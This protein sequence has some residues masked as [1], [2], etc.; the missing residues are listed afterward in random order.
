MLVRVPLSTYFYVAQADERALE[1]AIVNILC[2]FESYYRH[3]FYVAQADEHT[4]A[5]AFVN[6]MCWFESHYRNIFM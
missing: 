3:I 1:V 6:K 2:W 4:L 5:V